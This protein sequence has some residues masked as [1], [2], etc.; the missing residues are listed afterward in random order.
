MLITQAC[1]NYTC[2]AWSDK[3]KSEVQK[4]SLVSATN[5]AKQ[6]ELSWV[7]ER[8]KFE[9]LKFN[10]IMS[11]LIE[12]FSVEL[13]PLKKM[14]FWYPLKVHVRLSQILSGLLLRNYWCD[15]IQT[16]TNCSGAYCQHYSVQWFLS[17]LWPLNNFYF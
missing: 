5:W 15:F 7:F 17:E 16:S 2:T 4:T 9:S 14:W 13:W 3:S 1:Y 12:W 11:F 10:C 6:F 8:S